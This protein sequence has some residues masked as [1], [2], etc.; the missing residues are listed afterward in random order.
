MLFRSGSIDKESFEQATG[1][2]L[3]DQTACKGDICI[4]LAAEHGEKLDLDQISEEIGL[5]LVAE[6]EHELW[7]LGPGI[8]GTNAISSAE[9]PDLV[10]PDLE[11]RE[12]RLSS[13]L[14][15]KVLVYAW[16]PY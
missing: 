6:P 16:A 14:G 3:K 10:L 4:P 1:W 7:I 11:G 12:F 8:F 9:C 5:P 13:L 2:E 15:Q